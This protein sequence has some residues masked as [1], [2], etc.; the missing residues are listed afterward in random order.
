[1][2]LVWLYEWR[3]LFC[4][5]LE[6]MDLVS[7]VCLE[8]GRIFGLFVWVFYYVVDGGRM[9][10]FVWFVFGDVYFLICD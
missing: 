9:I 6:G 5:D 2:G 4:I 3:E 1:M 7:E 8:N 10:I